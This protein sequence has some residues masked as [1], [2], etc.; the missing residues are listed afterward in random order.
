MLPACATA[1]QCTK[2]GRRLLS[3][4]SIYAAPQGRS[5]SRRGRSTGSSRR[6]NCNRYAFVVASGLSPP[7][8]VDISSGAHL[9][10]AKRP[11]KAAPPPHPLSP[12]LATRRDRGRPAAGRP[13]TRPSLTCCHALVFDFW[14]HREHCEACRPEPCPRYEAWLEHK[15]GCRRARARAAHVRMAVPRAPTV[16]RRAPRLSALSAVPGLKRAISEVMDWRTARQLLSRAEAL[17]AEPGRLS[18]ER[19][20]T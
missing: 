3:R 18:A 6:A 19:S 20:T 13:P 15:A 14:T 4:F 9:R 1:G 16:P 8:C 7:S 5:A 12:R 11:G 17:R 2:T 10:T